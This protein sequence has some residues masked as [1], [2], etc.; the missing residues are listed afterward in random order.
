MT[1][2]NA[3]PPT[4][5]SKCYQNTA[6]YLEWGTFW[7]GTT[8][9]RGHGCANSTIWCLLRTT[10]LITTGMSA[11]QA[12]FL[13]MTCKSISCSNYFEHKLHRHVRTI[14]ILALL[15]AFP[16]MALDAKMQIIANSVIWAIL[17]D[18]SLQAVQPKCCLHGTLVSRNCSLN[19]YLQLCNV[20]SILA[21]FATKWDDK[22]KTR[23][24]VLQSAV[25]PQILQ[26]HNNS[27][28]SLYINQKE[29]VFNNTQSVSI[30]IIITENNC[31]VFCFATDIAKLKIGAY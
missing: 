4:A 11:W 24:N 7:I 31:H 10:M 12:N 23:I 13:R 1:I 14:L 20:R 8:G 28:S 21:T 29:R 6:R 9:T 5:V 3:I 19:M 22:S 17:K 2:F 15:I 30:K 16:I 26:Y 27:Y 25:L 18:P